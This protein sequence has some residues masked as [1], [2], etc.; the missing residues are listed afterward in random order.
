MIGPG[1]TLTDAPDILRGAVDMSVEVSP[2]G[3]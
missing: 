2:G 3:C 1:G